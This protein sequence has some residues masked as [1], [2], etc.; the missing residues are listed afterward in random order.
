[1]EVEPSFVP[2][3]D[4]RPPRRAPIPTPTTSEAPPVKVPTGGEAAPQ[5]TDAPIPSRVRYPTSPPARF[6]T[7]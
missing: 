4:V 2:P 7:Q 5:T 1:M 6:C 3:M